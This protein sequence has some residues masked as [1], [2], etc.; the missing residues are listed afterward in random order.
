MTS[1]NFLTD[2]SQTLVA[3]ASVL[4]N[5]NATGYASQI[6]LSLP[7]SFVVTERAFA[8]L[9]LGAAKGHN[10]EKLVRGLFD[11]GT[12]R[13]VDLSDAGNNLYR[14]LVDGAAE[15]TL[16]DG[17][18]ATIAYAQ[19]ASC[20]AVIDERKARSLCATRFPALAMASTVDLL[21][22]AAVKDAL[23]PQTQIQAITNA[24]RR[25]RMRVPPHQQDLVV[26]LIGSDE[27]ANCNSLPRRRRMT[28]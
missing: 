19:E 6:V 10:D 27:A 28:S 16:D 3:D 13:L 26:D 22:H 4:I 12:A 17:E 21:T 7:G 25:A 18:A 23:G 8:E 5:L 15:Q 24:L 14:S 20:V 9:K 1:S 11:A 2:P